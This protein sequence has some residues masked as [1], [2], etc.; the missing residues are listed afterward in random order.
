MSA[1]TS[2]KYEKH[3][4]AATAVSCCGGF[5]LEAT[6]IS[7]QCFRWKKNDDG[8]INGVVFGMSVSMSQSDDGGTL[9]ISGCPE[10]RIAEVLGYLD[11]DADY[12]AIREECLTLEPRL[13]EAAER[14][15]GIH[16]LRQEPWEALCS[17]VI[18]QNN[19]IPRIRLI[20]SRLC[21]LCGIPAQSC[22]P[23]AAEYSFPPPEKVAALRKEQ[24][25]GIGCGYRSEYILT[26][27]QAVAS[28]ELD[29]DALRAADIDAA[30]KTLLG[31]KGIG[32]K[33]A[34]CFLLYG[35]HRLECFP[36]DVW[37][38][39]ALEGEFKDTQLI[40]S[41]NAGVAQQYIFEYIRSKG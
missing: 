21:E 39:R 30:R 17:F 29:F 38:K 27:A 1:T 40:G 41:R 5:S 19:N 4:A 28:G 32:P 12:D 7:G 26:A 16:I 15:P 37:I 31:F 13:R 35:L 20:I 25:D 22:E 14:C 3:N 23:D 9:Y 33:V 2:G 18:S 24:L 8:T 11:L 36:R 10:E 34:D 6:L